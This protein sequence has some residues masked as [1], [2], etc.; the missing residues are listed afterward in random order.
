[1]GTIYKMDL[2]W[3]KKPYA[4]VK[5]NALLFLNG[6][7]LAKYFGLNLKLITDQIY[8]QDFPYLPAP[9]FLNFLEGGFL[10]FRLAFS[11]N[12]Q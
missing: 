4:I 9:C 7:T 8:G 12:R 11:I 6:A 5:F 10:S 2:I 3:V 1:M